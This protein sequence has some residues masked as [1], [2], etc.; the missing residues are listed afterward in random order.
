MT[1]KEKQRCNWW[2]DGIHFCYLSDTGR[3]GGNSTDFK[4]K[5]GQFTAV[6][7]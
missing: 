1:T 7:E 5:F 2:D 4:R 3:H 6:T